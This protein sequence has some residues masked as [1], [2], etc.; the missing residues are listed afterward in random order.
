MLDKAPLPE[1]PSTQAALWE[2]CLALSPTAHRDAA[3]LAKRGI[4]AAMLTKFDADTAAFGAMDPDT[5]LVQEGKVVTDEKDTTETAL[6]TA[7]Q[8][9]MDC[10]ALKDDPRTAAYKRF[11]VSDVSGLSQAKLHLAATM[12]VKQGRKYLAEY[13][14]KGLTQALLDEVARQDG[15][16]VDQM[17]DRHEAVSTRAGA[18]RARIVFANGLY[19]QLVAI[20]NAGQAAWRLTDA[21]KAHEYV[22]DPAGDTGPAKQP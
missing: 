10:V 14:D 3:E 5:V 18:T 22:V 4:T 8:A 13:A 16:F 11:G 12:A 2:R 6:E 21:Q 1:Y 7:I 17:T 15:L 19:R 20:A 9:V